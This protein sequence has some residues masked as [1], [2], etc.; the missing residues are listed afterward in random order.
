MFTTQD[1]GDIVATAC[2]GGI[3]YWA[4]ATDIDANG[5]WTVV[6]TESGVH[7]D[8]TAADLWEAKQSIESGKVGVNDEIVGYLRTNDV[9]MIDSITADCLVQAACFDGIIYG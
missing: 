7:I 2:Y 4:D 3:N 8:L 6:E 9:G 1:F 5:V